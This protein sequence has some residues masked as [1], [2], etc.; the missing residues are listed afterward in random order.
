MGDLQTREGGKDGVQNRRIKNI[1]CKITQLAKDRE[2][3]TIKPNF[4]NKI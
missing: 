4:F 1:G 3:S 2:Q